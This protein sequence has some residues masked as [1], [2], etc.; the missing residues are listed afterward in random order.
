MYQSI[1][2]EPFHS[3]IISYNSSIKTLFLLK[4]LLQYQKISYTVIEYYI[5]FFFQLFSIERRK[6]HRAMFVSAARCHSAV[7]EPPWGAVPR[8]WEIESRRS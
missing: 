8:G 4:L 2:I 7:C 6:P 1:T 3:I 5:I